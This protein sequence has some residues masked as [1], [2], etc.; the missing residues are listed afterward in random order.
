MIELIKK[1]FLSSKFKIH[2]RSVFTKKESK[3]KILIEFNHW[4]NHHI[5]NSYMA[6][7]LSRVYNAEKIGI[8]NQSLI[9]QDLSYN[10]IKKIKWILGIIFSIK[11]FGIYKSFGVNKFVRPFITH[12]IKKKTQK[13]INKKFYKISSLRSLERFRIDGILIGDL[14]YDSF[15][16]HYKLPTIDLNSKIFRKYFYESILLYHF[17]KKYFK[18]NNIS[19]VVVNHGVY[20]CALPARIACQNKINSFVVNNSKIFRLSNKN[21][22][23]SS[24]QKYFNE[25]KK[26]LSKK[27]IDMGI[28]EAKRRINLRLRGK[29]GVDMP[30]SSK[31]AF[32][33][34][35]TIKKNIIKKNKKLKIL[36][37][38][39][40]FSDSPHLL[41]DN[42][43]PDFYIWLNFLGKISKE[44]NYDWYIKYH[45]NFIDYFDKT[46]DIVNKFVEKYK[47]FTLVPSNCTH[48]YLKSRG[49]DVVL[50]CYGTIAFEYPLIGMP[51]INA[52]KN[53]PHA[54]YN[55]SVTP[56]NIHS[57]KKKILNLG[58][59]KQ[60]KINKNEIYTYY[61]LKNIY[62]SN[63][64]LHD[65]FGKYIESIGGFTRQFN[66]LVY[67]S[68]LDNWSLKKH[69]I[70]IQNLINFLN[71]NDYTF[72]HKHKNLSLKES[73]NLQKKYYRN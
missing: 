71:T 15:L 59:A 34:S 58:K 33:K 27:N 50:T 2:N 70:I 67:K 11:N 73:I 30:Y 14:I 35:I 49:I 1:I 57:Y 3:T 44:T 42:F 46:T 22:Y 52:S 72:Y 8:L 32:R 28:I 40:S 47:N 56:D 53:N 60:Y 64:W 41:G 51:A 24:E 10:F 16:K 37:A 39:H 38:A 25:I 43:F 66:H 48:Y 13:I 55:F 6:E 54:N 18:D 69:K 12:E 45:P 36:V 20:L 68:W 23:V 29:V 7:A 65:D 61:F 19:A 31:S 62:H 21:F 4:N 63:N 17:W 9:N 5:S 26:N